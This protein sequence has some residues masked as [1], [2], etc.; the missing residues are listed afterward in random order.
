M[1][2]LPVVIVAAFAL[3]VAGTAVAA[4]TWPSSA[5][6]W[7]GVNAHLNALHNTDLKQLSKVVMVRARLTQSGGNMVEGSVRCPGGS[8]TK[9]G[10]YATGGGVMF[11]DT[12]P[13]GDWYINRAGPITQMGPNEP[14]NG[15][16]AAVSDP[17]IQQGDPIPTDIYVYA[18]CAS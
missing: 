17:V 7:S 6:N 5:T 18:V 10:S 8:G 4:V 16:K 11:E 2:K 12:S 1:R 14:P 9:T 13:D 15:W 3:V